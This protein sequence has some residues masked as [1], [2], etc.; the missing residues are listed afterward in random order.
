M[1]YNVYLLS[2]N[3]K[4]TEWMNGTAEGSTAL[5]ALE[6]CRKANPTNYPVHRKYL[7]LPQ[8]ER[9]GHAVQ[10]RGNQAIFKLVPPRPDPQFIPVGT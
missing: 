6:R 2:D 9:Y 5:A 7:V 1:F 3:G 8:S 4:I 10:C